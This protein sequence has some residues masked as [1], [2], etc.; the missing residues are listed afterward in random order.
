MTSIS[1]IV[2]GAA[3]HLVRF[4]RYSSLGFTERE[5]AG[6]Q[7]RV[8]DFQLLL[9]EPHTGVLELKLTGEVDMATVTPLRETTAT[10]TASGDYEC[11]VLD[12]SGVSFMDSSGLHVLVETQRAM[13]AAGRAMKIVCSSSNLLKI[14]ELTGLDRVLTIV[15]DRSEAFAVAA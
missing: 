10:A 14:F 15:S 9:S 5:A 8:Q 1:A 13:T 7:V 11:L 3:A 6:R 2:P 4:S 12:L